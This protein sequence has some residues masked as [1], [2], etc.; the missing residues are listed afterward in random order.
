MKRS[1]ILL[2]TLSAL[3]PGAGRLCEAQWSH[4]P[5]RNNPLCVA[6]GDQSYPAMVGDG[7]GGAII[8]WTDA[9][10][11]DIDIYAQ[12]ISAA[13]RVEWAANGLPVCLA[14]ND[15]TAPTI[16]SDGE[17]GAILTWTDN[18]TGTND[19]YGQHLS[20]SGLA[21][22]QKNGV[23]ICSAVNDQVA[24]TLVADG[25]GGAIVAWRDLRGGASYDIYAQRVNSTGSGLWPPDGVPVCAAP[26]RQTDP[27]IATD[28]AGGAIIAWLDNRKGN[29]DL[30]AQRMSAS[31]MPLWSRDGVLISESGSDQRNP[32][33]IGDG[34][35]GGIIVWRD[36]RNGTNYDIYAERVDGSGANQWALNGIP[37]C[38]AAGDQE[39]PQII[40][41]GL[42]GGIIAWTDNRN[43][44]KDIFAQH[45]DIAGTIQWPADG[46][47]VCKSAGNQIYPAITSD[48]LGGAIIAWL[49][50]RH[51]E[52]DIYAQRI[53][54]LGASEWPA[55]GVAV[56][57]SPG[58]QFNP[59]IV[60]G[61]GRG[62]I[63]AWY[64]YRTG[65]SSD[66]YSQRV[67]RVG[68]LGDAAPH[69]AR[70]RP[71]PGDSQRTVTLLWN[72]SYVDSWPNQTVT[73]YALWRGEKPT[74]SDRFASVSTLTTNVEDSIY[75][76]YV[77]TVKPHW[78]NGYSFTLPSRTGGAQIG[79]GQ[80]YYMVSALTS[81]PLVY[82]DS[83]IGEIGQIEWSPRRALPPLPS[84]QLSSRFSF[85]PAP[86]GADSKASE[87]PR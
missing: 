8:T 38:T 86:P 73:S 17:G 71:A 35:G 78:L 19:I 53:G 66:I 12:H 49:D 67:D 2:M 30:Y 41:D 54:G 14:R 75:W 9:R 57:S 23:P 1:F 62:A 26:N 76:E 25:Q 6:P 40:N 27:A 69:L 80:E 79:E 13:G 68:Y 18:R 61:T 85:P 3:C 10:G 39:S 46:I 56:S 32:A 16:V 33:I 21:L 52:G 70:V 48:G 22:W 24:S 74:A 87:S 45:I 82:W 84:A 47:P 44:N 15:Q 28:A 51:G 58:E 83:E 11:S 34:A 81:D 4:D 64:D 5:L 55:D 60:T 36:A 59:V 42:R 29:A 50:Y 72:G 43:G 63:I 7:E 37:I 20:R 65:T 31:G 77:A